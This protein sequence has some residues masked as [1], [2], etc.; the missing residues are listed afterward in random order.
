MKKYITLYDVGRDGKPK[1]TWH[2][3]MVALGHIGA[4]EA[5][6]RFAIEEKKQDPSLTPKQLFEISDWG[7]I[8]WLV[9]A[10]FIEEND[11]FD[12]CF[13]SDI[14]RQD[15]FKQ[16]PT[17][18]SVKNALLQVLLEYGCEYNFGNSVIITTRCR[19]PNGK[20]IMEKLG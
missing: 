20:R 16:W 4:C 19:L 18:E 17:W 3:A 12:K 11:D 6:F 15:F 13:G 10:L 7:N 1:L 2:N 8:L 5:F 14:C 9:N